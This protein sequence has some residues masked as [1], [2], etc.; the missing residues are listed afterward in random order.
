MV[1]NGYHMI[2]TQHHPDTDIGVHI[3]DRWTYYALEFLE[4]VSPASQVTMENF[5]SALP[6][7]TPLLSGAIF[8]LPLLEK[9]MYDPPL[10]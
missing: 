5:A 2:L 3:I 10:L 9:R 6:S 7:D 4:G 1:R 8:S